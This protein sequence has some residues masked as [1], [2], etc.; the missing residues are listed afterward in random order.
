[1]VAS[2]HEAGTVR[3]EHEFAASAH[4][5]SS[6]PGNGTVARALFDPLM[7]RMPRLCN[8]GRAM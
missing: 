8:K 1:M 7:N 6:Q 5:R 4:G 3:V 2:R